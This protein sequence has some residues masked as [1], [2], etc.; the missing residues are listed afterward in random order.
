M[1]L[2][3]PPAV[4]HERMEVVIA[5]TEIRF[6]NYEFPG[7][8]VYPGGTVPVPEIRDIDPRAMPPEVRTVHGETLFLPSACQPELCEFRRRN[9]IPV[10]RRPD[11]WS[12]LLEPF[13]DTSFDQEHTRATEQRLERAGLS[14][15][16]VIEI[17][18]RVQPVMVAYNFDSMLW[19]WVH[20]GLFDLLSAASGSLVPPAVCATLG[21]PVTL[22]SWAMH[23][24]ERTGDKSPSG[25]GSSSEQN[26]STS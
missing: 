5:E 6:A 7:A 19:E 22:Y 3:R 23:I 13:L 10:R 25:A 2:V 15:A 16:E 11:I 12:D 24:A 18:R 1:G 21:D 14:P 26:S 17:R 4:H 20:L 9:A 8:T